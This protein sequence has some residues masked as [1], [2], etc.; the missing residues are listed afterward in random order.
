MAMPSENIPGSFETGIPCAIIK[1]YKV[2]YGRFWSWLGAYV[3]DGST[4]KKQNEQQNMDGT[5]SDCGAAQ[6]FGGNAEP[7]PGLGFPGVS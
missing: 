1:K 6:L 2:P 4:K 3:H 7:N 5:V